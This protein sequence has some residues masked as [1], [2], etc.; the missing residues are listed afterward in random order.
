LEIGYY[1]CKDTIKRGQCKRKKLF[2]FHGRAQVFSIK[3]RLS[4]DDAKKKTFFFSWSSA[5]IFYKVRLSEDNAKENV[6]ILFMVERKIVYLHRET[7]R[8]AQ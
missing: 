3:I 2:S 8:L 6:L 5:S 7:I 1:G 4:E